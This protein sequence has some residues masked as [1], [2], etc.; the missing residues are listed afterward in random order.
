MTNYDLLMQEELNKLDGK[1]SILLHSC[2]APCSSYVIERV[3]KYFKIIVFYYN[4]NIEPKEEYEKRKETQK[5]LI[6]K[7]SKKNEISFIEADY[8][9]DLYHEY[10]KGFE[11]EKE[12]GKRCLECFKLRLLTTGV[13]AKNNDI[14]YFT[15]TLTVSPHK[16][17]QIINE[18]GKEIANNL[19]IKFLP[20][21]F[22]KNNGYKKS[23]ELSQKYNLYRQN[24]CGCQYSK[25]N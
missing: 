15:T 16:N 21:D 12:G 25:G 22:K 8:N 20:A 17:C 7:L 23:I 6:T 18:L 11:E 3:L 1:P 14:D 2:C 4:P 19:N 9:N 10:I 5:K 24:Y 13:Y